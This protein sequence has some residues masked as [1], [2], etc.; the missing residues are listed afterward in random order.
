M[1]KHFSL[2]SVDSAS[3][4]GIELAARQL[5]I[6]LAAMR[7]GGAKHGENCIKSATAA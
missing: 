6:L 2:H 1:T 7:A 4:V 3:L 5:A